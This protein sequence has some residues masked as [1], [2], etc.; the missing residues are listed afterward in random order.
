MEAND[1][2]DAFFDQLK[3]FSTVLAVKLYRLRLERT[4]ALPTL[5]CLDHEAMLHE[6]IAPHAAA[7]VEDAAGHLHEIVYIPTNRRIDV[8]SVS[9]IGESTAESR[10]QFMTVLSERFPGLRVRA[11][12]I[13]WLRG[14][15][16]VASA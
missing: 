16:R 8:D 11:T 2:C 1:D 3:A 6:G 15:R 5:P 12:G 13:S 10:A 9:T 4:V 7:Y 14:D